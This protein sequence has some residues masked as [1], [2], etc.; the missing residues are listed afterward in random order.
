MA[1]SEV[2]MDQQRFSD[3]A[4]ARQLL[5]EKLANRIQ[6]MVG[7]RAVMLRD[8]VPPDG[9]QLAAINEAAKQLVFLTSVND[10]LDCT[11]DFLE[12]LVESPPVSLATEE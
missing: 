6:R 5:L 8:D 1:E 9:L 3:W 2:T 10:E 11:F 12:K 7:D 4:D